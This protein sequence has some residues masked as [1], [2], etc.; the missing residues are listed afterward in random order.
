MAA[1][2]LGGPHCFLEVAVSTSL[3]GGLL[4][5]FGIHTL[6]FVLP[7]TISCLL[8]TSRGKTSASVCSSDNHTKQGQP[9][10]SSGLRTF[11]P[12]AFSSGSARQHPNCRKSFPHPHVHKKNR[13]KDPEPSPTPEMLEGDCTTTHSTCIFTLA[14]A[15][16]HHDC[17]A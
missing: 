16:Q 13:R 2:Q 11:A 10:D 9:R 1:E 3:P 8:E 12:V 5:M 14:K 4:A 7:H 6:T 17:G 15:K